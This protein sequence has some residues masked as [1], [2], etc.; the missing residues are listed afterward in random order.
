MALLFPLSVLLLVSAAPLVAASGP[1]DAVIQSAI[2]WFDTDGNRMY[3]GG[4]NMYYENGIYYLIGEGK[5]VFSDCSACFN[6]YSTSDLTNWKFEGCALNNSAIVAPQPGTPYYRMERPKIFKCPST[7]RY[8]MWF[9]CDTPGFGMQSVGVLTS[10]SV[11]GP[12]E[13]ASPC[14]QPDGQKSYDMGT[15]V[16]VDGDG[17]AY[18]IRSVNNQFAGISQMNDA[19]TNVTGIIS[20]GPD[21]VS[22]VYEACRL[23]CGGRQA[24]RWRSLVDRRSIFARR[25]AASSNFCRLGGAFGG[26]L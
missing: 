15:F 24:G 16:D 21:M 8:V 14:F 3:A 20:S 22:A 4:A 7:Q 1:E 18:L 25:S 23:A 26:R 2:P 12:Y 10:D 19:C 6:L 11:T 5:K 13:F 17:K 9:H